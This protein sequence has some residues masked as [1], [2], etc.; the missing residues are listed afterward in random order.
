MSKF[1]RGGGGAGVSETRG[2][3]KNTYKTSTETGKKSN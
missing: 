3:A 1:H 2:E